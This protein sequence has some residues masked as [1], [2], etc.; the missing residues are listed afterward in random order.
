MYLLLYRIILDIRINEQTQSKS[1]KIKNLGF[2]LTY[3]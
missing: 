2:Y 1:Q 3:I